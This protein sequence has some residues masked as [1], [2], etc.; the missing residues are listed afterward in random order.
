[1]EDL[2]L[3]LVVGSVAIA[4]L[5]V[6]FLAVPFLLPLRDGWRDR[7]RRAKLRGYSDGS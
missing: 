6:V 7:W 3:R 4:F 1:M 2:Y 5:L